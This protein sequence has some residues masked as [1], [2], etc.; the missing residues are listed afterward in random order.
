MCTT[1]TSG[2]LI[3][4]SAEAA[5]GS[6]INRSAALAACS[7]VEA[8]TRVRTPPAASTA[9]A[10]TVPMKPGP[11]IPAR[12]GRVITSSP[13]ISR[14]EQVNEAGPA[15]LG[16]LRWVAVVCIELDKKPAVVTGF[17]EGRDDVRHVEDPAAQR[18]EGE[19]IGPEVLE[20]D[21]VDSVRVATDQLR[22]ITA[23]GGQVSRIGTET[24][25]GAAHDL[26]ELVRTLRHGGQVRVIRGGEP[27]ALRDLHNLVKGGAESIVVLLAGT[28]CALG[29]PADD[30]VL[31]SDGGGQVGGP[32]H[33]VKLVW[34]HV[35]IDEVRAAVDTHQLQA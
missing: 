13:F 29:P 33:S 26:V 9:R 23:A 5:G 7:K 19:W 3:S 2:A 11:M 21:V 15:D 6:I 16:C 12:S 10:W 24:N 8:A 31:S 25:A 28:D 1:S 27:S 34:K 17:A 22:R 18:H 14:K 32:R 30:K 35:C 4:S 20:V